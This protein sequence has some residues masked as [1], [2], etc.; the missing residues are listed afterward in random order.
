MI[1]TRELSAFKFLSLPLVQ[2]GNNL[3][4]FFIFSLFMRKDILTA[5]LLDVDITF[6]IDK[7]WRCSQ[8]QRFPA[9][10]SGL[11]LCMDWDHIERGFG[12]REVL[13]FGGF[14]LF[15]C[16]VVF[17]CF[18]GQFFFLCG[19]CSG[20]GIFVLFVCVC[21]CVGFFF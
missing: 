14:G 19:C 3:I 7:N 16:L 21:F 4:S 9:F 11:S 8:W 10:L 20:F 5:V 18:F 6:A 12:E 15:V 2:L 1:P 17:C 13:F